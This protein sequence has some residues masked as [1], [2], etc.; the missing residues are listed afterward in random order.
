MAAVGAAWVVGGGAIVGVGLLATSL[1]GLRGR[2]GGYFD[3]WWLGLCLTVAL[4]QV[5]HLFLPIDA[6]FAATLVALGVLGLVRAHAVRDA[7]DAVRE[8]PWGAAAFLLAG[9][10]LLL[11]AVRPLEIYDA[12]L[13][14]VQSIAWDAAY[15]VVAG[16]GNLYGRLAFYS[17]FF[18]LQAVFGQGPLRDDAYHVVAGLIAFVFLAQVGGAIVRL[19]NAH[20]TSGRGRQS[21]Y[22]LALMALPTLSTI[23]SDGLATTSPDLPVFI[24]G[25]LIVYYLVGWQEQA[26]T[27][28]QLSPL[29][30]AVALCGLLISIKLS[31]L[32]FG[33]ACLTMVVAFATLARFGG[34]RPGRRGQSAEA[35]L[36]TRGSVALGAVLAL[37][38]AL[39][40]IVHSIVLSGYPLYPSTLFGL[41]VD[42]RVPAAHAQFDAAG[43]VLYG[44]QPGTLAAAQLDGLTWVPY[45]L[46]ANAADLVPPLLGALV[47]LVALFYAL[48]RHI[49][50]APV[51][52]LLAPIYAAIGVWLVTAP[53]YRFAG[54]L[55][56]LAGA[57]PLARLLA[58][59]AS[60]LGRV[61]AAV[62]V[63]LS[64]LPPESGPVSIVF[65]A[66][67]VLLRR[68]TSPL[69]EVALGTFVTDSGLALNVPVDTELTWAAPLPATPQPDRYVY[70][71]CPGTL[72][73]G[74]ATDAPSE[75]DPS[76]PWLRS[77]APDP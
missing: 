2:R 62:F 57:V 48:T 40:A 63:L 8:N 67:V 15:P 68:G 29:V 21:D 74:F 65:R 71:R 42:W 18:V 20:R 12:G 72:A 77:P 24:V 7:R 10:W 66:P 39:G 32:A 31:G 49:A 43:I 33:L 73:C 41:P 44:R 38:L 23:G 37:V 51:L 26:P 46:A 69:P 3:A 35:T 36:E 25:T 56:W 16:L 64:V 54:A 60:R 17:G 45:W 27:E 76:V 70:A 55:I 34:A 13:Y 1:T 4:A 22:L 28:F 50:I 52:W 47:G 53:A 14:H 75:G 61:L 30:C 59:D 6:I 11:M 19:V 9:V 5:W 58:C